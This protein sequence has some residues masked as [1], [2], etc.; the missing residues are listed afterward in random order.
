MRSKSSK[1][2]SSWIKGRLFIF[3]GYFILDEEHVSRSHVIKVIRDHGGRAIKNQSNSR[4]IPKKTQC[5]ITGRENIHARNLETGK[6]AQAREAGI[7]IISFEQFVRRL[8]PAD[9]AWLKL[10]CHKKAA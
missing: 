10:K 9:R 7:Q 1:G 2:I 3:T 6:E 4:K 8:D 5:L